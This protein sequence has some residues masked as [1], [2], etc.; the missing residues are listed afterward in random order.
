[1]KEELLEILTLLQT[2][3][4]ADVQ[5]IDRL[6]EYGFIL[7]QHIARTG[8][9]MSEAKE[10]L[11]N[12]RRQAYLNVIASIGAQTEKKVGP[13]IIKDYINDCCA[14]QNSLYELAGRANSAC[15]H[16]NDLVR[17]AISALKQEAYASKFSNT[18]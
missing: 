9:L 5:S 10:M 3:S 6:L 14:E 13:M 15:T 11:H 4:Y 12:K 16:A 18:V 17:T 1:M 7:N 8:Q 2:T